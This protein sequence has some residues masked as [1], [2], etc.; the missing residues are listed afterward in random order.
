M[1]KKKVLLSDRELHAKVDRL[2]QIRPLANEYA[3]L[4]RDIKAELL[5]RKTT[6]ILTAEGNRAIIRSLPGASWVLEKLLKCLPGTLL[7]LLCP[8][9]PDAKKLNQRLVACPEDKALAACKIPTAGKLELA[10]LA[11]GE[12]LAQLT[13]VATEDDQAAA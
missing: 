2:V 10:V 3:L 4:C 1:A 7:D 13:S 11:K 8:R 5:A 6:E 9:R 12:T